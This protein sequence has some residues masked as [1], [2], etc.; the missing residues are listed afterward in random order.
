MRPRTH[1]IH[2]WSRPR[3]EPA[4][5]D[6]VQLVAATA[7]PGKPSMRRGYISGGDSAP[8]PTTWRQTVQANGGLTP[9]VGHTV[10][11]RHLVIGDRSRR[12]RRAQ[13]V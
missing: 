7:R 6:D 3:S 9:Q 11:A 13:G 4:D 10:R 8:R 12:L 1:G 5:A 2:V